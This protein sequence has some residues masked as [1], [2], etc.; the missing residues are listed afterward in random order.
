[1]LTFLVVHTITV[2]AEETPVEQVTA[3]DTFDVANL[4]VAAFYAGAM[5]SGGTAMGGNEFWR[6][7]LRGFGPGFG[8][9]QGT[10]T[11]TY[12][13]PPYAPPTSDYGSRRSNSYYHPYIMGHSINH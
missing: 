8:S 7:G 5:S 6:G 9:L 11:T 4:N 3:T 13:Y 12:S 2:Y 10:Q 1:M